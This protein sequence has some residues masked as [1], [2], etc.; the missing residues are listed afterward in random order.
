[1]FATGI[2]SVDEPKEILGAGH[3]M[4]SWVGLSLF[5]S[6]EMGP[7]IPP[8]IQQIRGFGCDLR[9]VALSRQ[10]SFFDIE[11]HVAPVAR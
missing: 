1:M 9:A 4:A 7:P 5:E 11:S 2:A 10:F 8:A 3:E 6:E